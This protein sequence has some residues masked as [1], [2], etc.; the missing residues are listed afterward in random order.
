[1]P[2]C[3]SCGSKMGDSDK[4][5]NKCG[6]PALSSPAP[7]RDNTPTAVVA[8]P[9]IQTPVNNYD[10]AYVGVERRF[11]FMGRTLVISS[12][13][14]AFNY[15]RT[16]FRAFARQQ[17]A[18]LEADYR[19]VVR[20]LDNFLIEFPKMYAYHRKPLIDCAMSI[21]LQ[22]GVY[23]LSAKQ[24]EDQH[25]EDFCLCGDI[26]NTAIESF[27]LTIEANQDRKAR[28]YNMM[29]GVVF[30][31]I[32]GFAAALALN[33]A[34]TSIAE[35]DIRNANVSKK[36]RAEIFG[37]I[38]TADLMESVF[39]DYWRVF[40][41]MTWQLNRKGLDMW[42]PNTEDNESAEGLLQNLNSGMLPPSRVPDLLIRL[43]QLNPYAD[44]PLI[45]IRN[46]IGNT[47]ETVPIFE[48]F[49]VE[50]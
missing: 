26:V 2:F 45:Y 36:Q 29:P 3:Y 7:T 16:A 22:S 4:F 19:M 20:D 18:A 33:V 17:A 40:L 5:C 12:G 25:T 48:Y 10:E 50:G 41:S 49:G 6:K 34:M 24:F 35:A 28:M 43:I 32:G 15:Y 14:D 11:P 21:I 8:P 37:R 1:M 27:N 42:Y 30:S 13:M 47:N 9:T 44:D 31:G 23:D 39:V 38:D 46:Y